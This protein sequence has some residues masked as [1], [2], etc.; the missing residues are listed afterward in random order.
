M[1]QLSVFL[2]DLWHVQKGVLHHSVLYAEDQVIEDLAAQ[3]LASM[4]RAS[5]HK[6]ENP[7]GLIASED[8][9]RR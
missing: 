6:V 7:A 3:H 9:A 2:R 1:S 8:L 4:L 5:S